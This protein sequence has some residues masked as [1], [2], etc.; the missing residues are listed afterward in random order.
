MIITTLLS[1]FNR[2]LNRLHAEIAA[3]KNEAAIWQ[4]QEQISNTAGNLCLHLV[5]NLNTYIG[6]QLG[7]TGYVRNRPQEF[8]LKNIPRQQLLQAVEETKEVVANTLLQL[9]V[10]QL[11]EEYPQLVLETKTSTG[12]MLM[13]LSTHLNYHLGQINYH[14]RILDKA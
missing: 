10:A 4:L 6:A 1:L 14:R 7:H 13:H 12:Y 2:D 9:N 3:Y 5:G 8:A 11:E